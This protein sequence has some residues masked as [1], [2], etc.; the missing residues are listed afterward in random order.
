MKI[1]TLPIDTFQP[2]AVLL[3]IESKQEL[4]LLIEV[5][6]YNESIPELVSEDP[7]SQQI[8]T[9]FLDVLRAELFKKL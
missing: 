6:R 8:V 5:C 1:E 7:T 9:D 4:D 3:T 2:F